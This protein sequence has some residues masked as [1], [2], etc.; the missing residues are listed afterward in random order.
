MLTPKDITDYERGTLP[1]HVF[2]KKNIEAAEA[3]LV[4]MDGKYPE[5]LMRA[6]RPGE[7][8]KIKEYRKN[9]YKPKTK[10]P[11]GKVYST[12]SKIRKSQDWTIKYP[13]ENPSSIPENETLYNYMELSFFE[14]TSFTNWVFG[15]LLRYYDFDAN[16]VILWLP[17]NFMDKPDNEYLKPMPVIFTSEQIYYYDKK[18]YVLKS[19][20]KSRAQNTLNREYFGGAVYYVVDAMTIQRFE[21]TD[22]DMN[23]RE[24]WKYEHNLGFMPVVTMQG[25]EQESTP[26][27]CH[28]LSRISPMVPDLDEAACLSS[29]WKAEMLLH[30]N[31]K[32]W[33]YENM[34]CLKC[35]GSTKIFPSSLTGGVAKDK[36]AP[37]DCPACKGKGR[38]PFDPFEYLSVQSEVG[39]SKV[40][41]PP[42]GYIEK[43]IEA[44][45]LLTETFKASIHDALSSV[46]MEILDTIPLYQSGTAKEWDRTEPNAFLHSNAEDLVRIMDDSYYIVN[47]YRYREIIT[48]ESQREEMLP[49]IPVPEKF[50]I[51]TEGMLQQEIINLVTAK[52][53]PALIKST[54]IEYVNKKYST[55]DELRESMLLKIELDP[56]FGQPEDALSTKLLNKGI[57][58]LNYTIHCNISEFV[59]RM[60]EENKT[61]P[62][63]NAAKLDILIR[64]AEEELKLPSIGELALQDGNPPTESQPVS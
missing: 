4:H 59:D 32:F 9:Y 51:L 23:F 7:S 11:I 54:S 30:V 38:V 21:Q 20:E 36:E 17:S 53:D 39:E 56:F 44:A 13:K 29:D 8:E 1:K 41:T 57:S 52:A 55:D 12:Q 10:R 46:G 34:T 18:Q 61:L 16:A 45:K 40:P 14:Y 48:N 62:E 50:D 63:D 37:I 24:A 64:Y 26:E 5:K 27:Q 6:E 58:Q 2:Y 31:S 35:K 49:E 47:E 43:N 25:I 28:Y 22:N 15:I 42:G 3:I 60:I 19:K 33:V